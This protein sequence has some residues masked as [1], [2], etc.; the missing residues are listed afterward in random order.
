M[1]VAPI[2]LLKYF[3]PSRPSVGVVRIRN[4]LA[5]T[6]GAVALGSCA[7]PTVD[8]IKNEPVALT[9]TVAA[10]WDQVGE[11][12]A[13]Y[14]TKLAVVNY[15]PVVRESRAEIILTAIGNSAQ[16]TALLVFD[17]RGGDKTTTVTLKRP[18]MFAGLEREARDTITKC[19]GGEA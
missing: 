4:F 10:P 6:L 12:I 7:T 18:K 17:I 19:G 8:D 3:N 13:A 5:L 15:R 11:C 2:L 14:Y 16:G 9:V 1:L